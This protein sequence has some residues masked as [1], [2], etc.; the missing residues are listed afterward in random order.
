MISTRLDDLDRMQ[1][2]VCVVGAG[3]VGIV[4]ALELARLGRSVLLLES[5]GMHDSKDAQRLADAAIVNPHSHVAMDIAVARRLGG[6]SNLWG[7]RCVA[8]EDF[9][10]TE[11]A[12]VPHSGWPIGPADVAPYLPAACDYLGCGPPEFEDPVPDL[13]VANDDFRFVRLERWSKTPRIG[14]LYARRLRDEPA[15]DLRLRATVVGLEHAE[16]GRVCRVRVRQHGGREASFT[17]RCVVLAA[18]G[19][20]NA[21]LLLATQLQY[22]GSFGGD[23]GPLGRY[24]MGHLYGSVADMVIHSPVL[25]AGIDYYLGRDGTYV[26]RRF[27]P[28]AALQQRMNLTNLALWPDYPAIH[29]PSHG[30]GILSFAYLSLSV[31][32]I[33]R[34]I[35]VES[36]R[37]HYLGPGPIHRRPHLVNVLRN[38]PGTI[39]FIPSFLYRRYLARPPMPGFFQRNSGR[40]YSIRFHAEHL[41]NPLSRVTLGHDTDEL[42]LRKLNIDLRYTVA[43]TIPLL[44]AH[45]CFGQWLENTGLGALTW[46][47]PASERSAYILAQCYDGH[48]QIGITRMSNDARNGVV[49]PDCRVFGAD[50]LFIAG[51][52]VFPTSAEANPTLLAVAL[53]VRLAARISQD[54]CRVPQPKTAAA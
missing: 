50:N 54:I 29:D 46:A 6:A 10:F 13:T 22:P 36:I 53:A 20:E 3:P 17:P 35:V 14:A 12:A 21:R 48:H 31:P 11:R 27:T 9:D 51:S 15:I 34:R 40:R 4:L 18:G 32:P 28:S 52:S 8:M 49:G 44:R 30:N 37:Q 38:A 33:G 25:D 1:H 2:D 24:Y 7:G 5:G 43:D 19:L 47:A 23:D 42:G 41:P 45:E 16:D 26:R 39:A